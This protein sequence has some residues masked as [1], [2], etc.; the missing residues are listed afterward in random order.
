[1]AA[2][3][4]EF[5][6]DGEETVRNNLALGKY[7]EENRRYA[8]RWIEIRE[9]SKIDAS[10]AEQLDIARSAKN[11][12]VEAAAAAR[13]AA[14]AALEQA[15]AAREAN[16]VAKEANTITRIALLIAIVAAVGA[17]LILFD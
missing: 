7:R 13:V 8:E 1:M 16:A 5:E 17:I 11:A 12:A 10:N 9:R 4:A 2:K 3:F 14:D 6:A 15:A